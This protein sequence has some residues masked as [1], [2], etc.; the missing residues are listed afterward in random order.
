MNWDHAAAGVFIVGAV[1]Q[2]VM[3]V[4]NMVR[5]NT[6]ETSAGVRSCLKEAFVGLFFAHLFA[7]IAGGL[8]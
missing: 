7:A 3:S 6:R 5:A 2:V 8:L 1:F 4:L